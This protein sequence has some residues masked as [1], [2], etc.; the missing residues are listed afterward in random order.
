MSWIYHLLNPRPWLRSFL[1]PAVGL[2][3]AEFHSEADCQGGREP[4]QQQ[5]LQS[6]LPELCSG[7][8]LCQAAIAREVQ[9][10]SEAAVAAPAP[11]IPPVAA[12]TQAQLLW[13]KNGSW[14]PLLGATAFAFALQGGTSSQ[15]KNRVASFS[16]YPA[17]SIY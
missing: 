10:L 2:G 13:Q 4:V 9:S 11:P 6:S 15:V 3:K 8:L 5:W 7:C 17:Q 1:Q 14:L 12:E 16:F